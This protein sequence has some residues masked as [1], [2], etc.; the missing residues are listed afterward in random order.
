MRRVDW[1]RR[2]SW[3]D[4]CTWPAKRAPGFV[5]RDN[6][7]A[8]MRRLIL[9]LLVLT[10][11]AAPAEAQTL[12]I[13]G[14]EVFY[15]TITPIVDPASGETVKTEWR[16]TDGLPVEV[17]C[18][19]LQVF[20]DDID[21]LNQEN[22]LDLRGRV[23]F[24]QGGTR[25]AALS[26]T[27][28]LK[29]R[30]G[31]FESAS[32]TLQLTD[33]QVDR[34]LFGS[35]EPEATFTAARIEKTGP[36]TYRLTDATFTTCVQPSRRWQVHSD[37]LTFTVNRYAIMTNARL[38]VKDVPLLYLPIFYYPISENDR[39]TGFLMPSYGS[40]TF[41]GFTLSNAF[42]WAIN[43]SQDLTVYHDWF[44]KSGQGVGSDY[45]Y[46][47]TAGAGNMR[48]HMINE[49]ELLADDGETVVSPAKRSYEFRGNLTQQL[50]GR[51][52][53]QAR[54]DFFTD[55]TTQQLY[56]NDLS[57]FT[58]RSRSFGVDG[59]GQ[60]GRLRA[61]MQAE[62]S[63]VFNSSVTTSFRTQPRV[64]LNVVEA[65]IGRTRIYAGGSVE[66]LSLVRI[67]DLDA[68]ET[69]ADIFR[70]DATVS[71]RTTFTLGPALRLTPSV[72]ARRTDWNAR[73]DPDTGERVEEPLTRHLFEARVSMTG[74]VFSR[75]F[76]TDGNRWVE[77]VKHVI[78]PTVTIQRRSAFDR[79]D[80]VLAFEPGVDLLVGN[81]TQVS[82][83]LTNSLLARVR[84]ADGAP[85]QVRQLLSLSL[86]Q[87]YYTDQRAA[88]YDRQNQSSLGEDGSQL[89]PPTNF[90]PI[91]ASLSLT[92]SPTI[93]GEFGFEYDTRFD[94][95]RSYRASAMISR[96]IL[97]FTGSWTKQQVIPGLAG[98]ADPRY[99]AH[100]VSFS[101]RFKKP[102][103]RASLAY[104][105]AVD[106][107]NS[108]F[109]QHRF[110]AFYNAQCC[111][112]AVDYVVVNLSH[113]GLRNDKRF[114]FSFSLAGI[115]SFVNPLGVF[116]NNGR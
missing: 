72:S 115:G 114:S 106:I 31:S 113:Y 116:G 38:E 47:G 16:R 111:G 105:T 28:D 33:R 65:P 96:P 97:D 34:S 51:V 8:P 60:W 54:A 71:A 14:C 112:I 25:I 37:K 7:A 11:T 59:S 101:S 32:G 85:A 3:L 6:L 62:R 61:T 94:A 43:R 1:G 18:P 29:T 36:Q 104:A 26:G 79:F 109:L 55:A 39:A 86:T 63:D 70:T 108:R 75:I 95:V 50:P 53:V 103:G 35:M 66:A 20:A 100:S 87:S 83:G 49:R 76:N 91:R 12:T 22:R 89:P 45:R 81:V 68:P 74:P 99:A 110:G 57:V 69:R 15:S 9:C 46:V 80:E 73:L 13:A 58:R 64:N 78:E 82:Y 107:L 52:R 17:R 40:S 56:Q 41:R 84:Q 90:T 21:L 27:V 42:F 67:A 4:L 44:S 30:L 77:R 88:S 48:F 23:V 92:P 93:T 10:A 2:L 5:P 98:Y 24:Q 102:D 19:D